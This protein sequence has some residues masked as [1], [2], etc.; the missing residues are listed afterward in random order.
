MKSLPALRPLHS[1]RMGLNHRLR[2]SGQQGAP[3]NE[4][5]RRFLLLQRRPNLP[6]DFLDV[7]QIQLPMP[8]AR[9]AHANKRNIGVQHRSRRVAC[10]VQAARGVGLRYQFAH[11]GFDDGAA[12]ALHHLH[13]GRIHI[14]PNNSVAHGSETRRRHRAHISQPEYADRQAHPFPAPSF[15]NLLTS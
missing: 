14:H 2:G 9:R 11:A 7:A 15:R 5:V 4:R 3:Q 8:Q 12:P 10:S 6:R 13:F 1:S